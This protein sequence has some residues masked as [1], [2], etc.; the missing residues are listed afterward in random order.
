MYTMVLDGSYPN[1]IRVRKEAESLSASERKLIVICRWRDGELREE[2]IDNVKIYRIGKNYTHTRK[3]LNDIVLALFFIDFTFKRNIRR[4]MKLENITTFHVHDLP[5]IRTILR[6]KGNIP[7][8][9]DMHENYPEMLLILKLSNKGL[10]M[11]LKDKLFYNFGRWKRYEKK[12][13][14]QMDHIIAVIDEMKDKLI[15]EYQIDSK[16]ISIISNYEKLDF[17]NNEVKDDFVF[18]NSVFYLV[19]VGGIDPVRGLNTV[20]EALPKFKVHKKKVNFI[21]VGGGNA[22][23]ISYLKNL[24]LEFDCQS[25][26]HFLGHK[27]FEKINYYMKNSNLNIIPHIKNDHTDNTIPHKLFQ[28][29]SQKAPVLVSSCNPMQRIIETKDAGFVFKASDPTDLVQ[30][31]L[32]LM[33]DTKLVNERIENAYNLVINHY[34]WENES[35]KL[36]QLYNKYNGQQN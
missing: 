16:K 27:S 36:I 17:S 33:N 4:I 19:Y 34:N 8:I 11:Q 24:A 35:H 13:I 18:D 29:M 6:I 2:T 20:I 30:V 31:V 21:I 14:H 28:I 12:N 9:L 5:L 15:R 32:T 1:D 23:Y 7:I 22:N 10:L 26:V 3:G 25:Q